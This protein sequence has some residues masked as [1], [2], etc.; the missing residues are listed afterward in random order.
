MTRTVMPLLALALA[1]ATPDGAAAQADVPRDSLRI[2]TYNS[3]LLSPIFRCL[4]LADIAV[5]PAVD[6]L[7]QIDGITERWA[8]HLADTILADSANIDVIALNEV[9]DEDAKRILR[10]RLRRVYPVQVYDIDKDLVDVRGDVFVD[11]PE[12][13]ALQGDVRF[14]GEDSGLMLFAKRDFRV[15]PLPNPAY[16]WGGNPDETLGATTSEVAFTYFDPCAVE[17]CFAAKGAGLIRLQN[18]NEGPVYNIVFTHMQA[19][20][21]GDPHADVRDKQFAAVRRMIEKTLDPLSQHVL[22]NEVVIMAGDLNV[23]YLDPAPPVPTAEWTQRFDT[24]SSFFRLPLYDGMHFSGGGNDLTDTNDT[25][26]QRL[27]YILASPKPATDGDAAGRQ[28]CVQHVT[29]PI[30]YRELESDHNLVHA[31]IN[32]AFYHCSPATAFP[33]RLDNKGVAIVDLMP[34][35]T[36]DVT[37]IQTGGAMQWFE[38]RAEG[39]ATYSIGPDTDD[40][41]VEIYVPEDLTTPIARYNQTPA[42]VGANVRQSFALNQYVLPRRFFIRTAGRTRETTRNY[43]LMVKRHD[44]ASRATAC[45]LQPGSVQ[46]VTLSSAFLQQGQTGYQDEAWFRFD[47]AGKADTG[48]PQTITLTAAIADEPRVSAKLVDYSDPL[49]GTLTEAAATNLRSYTGP[50]G[51]GGKG[52]LVIRQASRANTGTAVKATLDTNLRFITIGDLTCFDETNPELG[53]DDIYT[54]VTIDDVRKRAPASGYV[55]YDCDNN[56]DSKPWGPRIGGNRTKAFFGYF[57]MQVF[58]E[59]DISDD[60]EA[61]RVEV[62]PLAAGQNATNGQLKWF[63][64]DGEYRFDYELRRRPNAPVADP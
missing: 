11:V 10:R 34:G 27:D 48:D 50:I 4:S 31:D 38:V 17:D 21:A 30:K 7:A 13:F 33:V 18:G 23:T 16:R 1:L 2:A 56:R 6:C 35:G 9:W 19:D 46:G 60:D 32:R 26:F 55:E 61:R 52:Y 54:R 40:V 44:C 41:Q 62:Q 58:E 3:Y 15:L 20:Y 28:R 36:I 51:D 42:T 22:G 8:N 29:V 43:A 63:F 14:N 53:S 45:I 49:G 12:A 57:A 39:T 25:D 24:G 64:E 5:V 59:D 37:K 47:A